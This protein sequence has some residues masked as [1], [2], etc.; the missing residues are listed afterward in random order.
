MGGEGDAVADAGTVPG[1]V[2]GGVEGEVETAGLLVDDRPDF[3]GP[4]V[5]LEACALVADLVRD[6]EAYGEV[7]ALGGADARADVV[8]DPLDALAVAL[9]GEDVEADLGPGGDALSELDGFVLSVVGGEGAIGL[10]AGAGEGLEAIDGEVA[11]EL[12]HEHFGRDG[13]R[14]IDLD[15]VII[16][17]VR[18]G[19]GEREEE[20][21]QVAEAHGLVIDAGR[22]GSGRGVSVQLWH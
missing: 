11:V 8:A 5:G 18:G 15:L 17:R 21:K 1:T 9:G 20:G 3:P 6:A 2:N 10:E 19:C 16:L 12:D 22:A 13:F 14:T 7:P 4:G